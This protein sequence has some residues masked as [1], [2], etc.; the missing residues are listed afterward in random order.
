MSISQ[1]VIFFLFLLSIP[2][3]VGKHFWPEFSF[4]NGIRVDYLSPTLYLSDILFIF[5]FLFSIKSLYGPC[6]LILKKP[7]VGLT[8][9]IFLLGSIFSMHFEAVFYFIIKFLEFLY[10]GIFV[11][12]KLN[13]KNLS[14]AIWSL[15]CG[16][17]TEA[18]IM[19]LQ[20]IYQSSLGGWIYYLGERTFT[21]S[22]IGIS[23]FRWGETMLLRPYGTFPHPNVA[24]FYFFFC[25]T[26]FLFLTVKS[27][28]FTRLKKIILCI[29]LLGIVLSFSR[30]VILLTIFVIF[31]SFFTVKIR[32]RKFFI[33]YYLAC[34]LVLLSILLQR[35]EFSFLR[36]IYFRLDLIK[37][38]FLVF[39]KNPIF[40]VGLGNFYYHEILFQRNITPTLLQPVHNIYLLWMVQTGLAGGILMF[41]FLK[42]VIS[43]AMVFFRENNRMKT[44]V[45]LVV[46]G[47]I[48]I[49]IFD[50]YLIT[51]QQGQVMLA[52][53]LGLTFSRAKV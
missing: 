37:I 48:L 50:H 47:T 33:G 6:L 45:A 4:V 39:L 42:K 2:F 20:F 35:L 28:N 30:V 43:R 36:D 11:S 18:V 3:Q 25:F 46:F 5:L 44:S 27:K 34:S 26:L 21:S 41:I 32:N 31:Y 23:T 51:L 52:L 7:L 9:S 14:I 29:L 13:K 19:F 53:L 16:A 12:Y 22:T 17:V 8:L 40:G 49:G 10:I 15:C 24:A 38:A 1:K